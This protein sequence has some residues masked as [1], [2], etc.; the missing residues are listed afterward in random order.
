MMSHYY[1]IS[2]KH[3]FEELDRNSNGVLDDNELFYFSSVLGYHKVSSS[4]ITDLKYLFSFDVIR[5]FK[6]VS[7]F[8]SLDYNFHPV[9]NIFNSLK[10]QINLY[11][12]NLNK[13][14]NKTNEGKIN[15]ETFIKTG[16]STLIPN[17]LLKKN[18]YK[19]EIENLDD[20]EF[21][22]IRD[23][24][25]KVTDSLNYIMIK[26]PKFICLNDD[27]NHT[28]PNELV[29]KSLNNFYN[30]YFPKKS[31][32]ELP[33]GVFNRFLHVD[34]YF[35]HLNRS[36]QNYWDFSKYIFDFIVVLLVLF[37]LFLVFKN[38]KSNKL[39]NNNN[40]HDD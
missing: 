21:H 5:T 40:I 20:I 12:F 23:D 10:F 25:E 14:Y 34:E 28:T 1:K 16:I 30:W 35:N 6:N 39:D 29:I 17:K 9:D 19:F 2:I 36:N 31:K 3:Y 33:D 38:I 26:K 4:Q 13:N 7:N 15:Y 22:M 24:Y 11:F 37:I 18:K 8:D 32:F 27:M